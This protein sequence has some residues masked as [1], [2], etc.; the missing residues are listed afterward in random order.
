MSEAGYTLTE[1]LAALLMIGLA[2]GG[3]TEGAQVVARIQASAGRGVAEG[4]RLRAADQGLRRLLAGRGPFTS[5]NAETG[6][7]AGDARAFDFDCGG[8]GR[9]GARLA[10][11]AP[12]GVARARGKPGDTVVFTGEHG[13]T[14]AFAPAS[15]RFLYIGERT[16]GE[17]WPPADG[18]SDTLREVVLRDPAGG[19]APAQ[20]RLWTEQGLDCVYDAI[21]QACR[22]P[23]AER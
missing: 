6:G 4:A 15:A 11:T 5:A 18:A 23:E 8:S 1:M 20:A 22:A 12:L 13:A 14:R 16:R 2:V 21:A 19:A 17:V 10:A 7:L 9:C 3:L